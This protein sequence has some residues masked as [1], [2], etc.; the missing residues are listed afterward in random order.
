MTTAAQTD[1][2]QWAKARREL[3]L[4]LARRLF[5]DL[6]KSPMTL[7]S[8]KSPG[9]SW[10]L[11]LAH[12]A[13]AAVYSVSLVS[14]IAGLIIVLPPWT[15]V[16]DPIVGAM[17]MLLGW[18]ARPRATAPPDYW[19]DRAEF[20]TL[21]AAADRI[22]KALGT[23]PVQA[24]ARSVEFNANFRL[25]GWSRRPFVELGAPLMA[26]LSSEERLALIAHELS[27]GA[28]RDPL[29]SS[30]LGGAL[31]ALVTWS[32]AMRPTSFGRAGEGVSFGPLVSLFVIPFEMAMLALSEAVLLMARGLFMLVLRQSQ[33][34]EYLADSLAAAVVGTKPMQQAL[35]K[36]YLGE[37]VDSAVREHALKTPSD[38]LV[39]R[40]VDVANGVDPATK[41]KLREASAAAMW[42]A[43]VSHPPTAL[44][45]QML[46][47]NPRPA[48]EGLL[49]P[50]ESL[51]L[52]REMAR[53]VALSE[54][55]LVH[56]HVEAQGC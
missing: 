34:A 14:G 26:V 9:V 32:S 5:D 31:D 1:T 48:L 53:L 51:A 23:Q 56:L 27:H 39:H 4:R 18:A 10:S 38:P 13:A 3:G 55:E 29:R 43:D 24:L 42:Q 37:L 6:A 21:Y 25:A 52:D 46:G 33:R 16:F 41:D 7:E 15:T 54:R 47:L 36:L 22:A 20:P 50:S 35:E 40:L 11:I 12:L 30:Y 44:R 19:L 49:S 45:V 28:N 17:L 8:K 2:S